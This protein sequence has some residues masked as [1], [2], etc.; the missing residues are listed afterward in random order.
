[1]PETE[2]QDKTLS[3]IVVKEAVGKGMDSPLRESILEAVEEADGS[4]GGGTR[5]LPLVGAI[6]G[7][8]AALGFLAG[9]QST[10]LEELSLEET[11]LEDI[12][13][14]EIIDEIGAEAD[15]EE[16]AEMP[17]DS[18]GESGSSPL[19]RLLLA[20]GLVAGL[21][22]LRRRFASG[23]DDEWEPI[24]EFEPATDITEDEGEEAE[25]TETDSDVEAA[26]DESDET[27]E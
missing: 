13:E 1:M 21:A 12:E 7:A 18:E 4:N 9:R 6:F 15:E 8:G 19:G 20:V 22:Y 3:E 23:E 10:D 14:P 26:A 16:S 5:S 24:E 27:E 2:Q 11:P 25:T 17:S